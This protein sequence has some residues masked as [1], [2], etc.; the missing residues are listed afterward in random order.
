MKN[1]DFEY[2]KNQFDQSG[3][4]APNSLDEA[5]VMNLLANQQPVQ[6][7]PPQKPKKK[8]AVGIS[9][10]AAVAVIT[11]GAITFTSLHF[12]P[13]QSGEKVLFGDTAA[14]RTF[15]GRAQIQSTLSDLL[16]LTGQSADSFHY[17]GKYS[18]YEDGAAAGSS[19]GAAAG[20]SYGAMH[21]SS[22]NS[23]YEQV[24]GVSE[25]DNVKTDGKYIY[26]LSNTKNQSIEVF[27][28]EAENSK[29]VC[30]IEI[31]DSGSYSYAQDFFLYEGKLIALSGHYVDDKME[32]ADSDTYRQFQEMTEVQIFDLSDINHVT[33]LDSFSQSGTYISSRMI[34][35][36]LYVVSNDR[37]YS[38]DD[39]PFVK[40]NG[41]TPDSAER[42]ELPAN[43]I[44]SVDTPTVNSF[45]VVSSIDAEKSAQA[46]VTKAVLGSAD[47]IYC[48]QQN[49]YVTAYDY[50]PSIYADMINSNVFFGAYAS[51]SDRSGEQ[52]QIIKISL[53]KDLRFV[54]S[55]KVDGTIDNQY[56]LDEYEGN[57]RVATTTYG[58]DYQPTNNLYVLDE[59]LKQIGAVTGFADTETIRAVR[60]INDT[61]YVITYMQTDP[62]FVIDLS[63]PTA[64][65]IRGEVKISGF[66]S[67]LV[68]VD[69]NTLLGIGYH[70][71]FNEDEQI[72]DA[73]ESW[74]LKLV[75][76]DVT[77]K[78]NPLVL[79]AKVF[80]HVSSGVQYNPKALLVNFERGDYAVPTNYYYDGGWKDGEY[81]DYEIPETKNG[82]INFR[83]DNGN[84]TV[85]DDYTSDKITGEF[86][87]VDR[88]VYVGDYI[89]LLGSTDYENTVI[90][91]V[92]YK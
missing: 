30:N 71:G 84:I 18:A 66:S 67:L 57:L 64:P 36:M 10:A 83:I 77:D 16:R 92:K 53:E 33:L 88:C 55:N 28:A 73:N 8:L 61:A 34:D 59:K 85:I 23:T 14:L 82:V 24:T 86:A 91:C 69:E 62:L 37:V 65:R 46:A 56:S 17:S 42:K 75:T 9:A 32:K 44:Y 19:S 72:Y 49:L 68:P 26:Y 15:S 20:S 76:F 35:G 3:V 7:I 52:T 25:A 80:P 11:A 79:D 5:E 60:Y 39:L 48:N 12:N 58:E 45:L 47:I 87:S 78:S 89:Y 51:G 90:D 4:N 21:D 31:S 50:P 41:A 22:H 54:A 6:A 40:H 43:Q 74:G 81:Y 29:K 2:I 70:D 1:N 63:V 27:S 13:F 38:S